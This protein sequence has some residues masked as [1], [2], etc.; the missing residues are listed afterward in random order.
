LSRT[1]SEGQPLTFPTR[2][3][4]AGVTGTAGTPVTGAVSGVDRTNN[5]WYLLGAAT[6]Y[7]TVQDQLKAKLAYDFSPTMR[8]TYTFGLW[9]NDSEGRPTPTC[10]TPP[11]SRSTAARSTSMAA[12]TR[13]GDRLQSL[14]RRPAA[15]HARPDREDQHAAYSM[16]VAAS[17]YDYDKDQLRGHRRAAGALSGGRAAW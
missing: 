12:A 13:W 7:H 8:A 16:E 14:Q 9:R 4:A 15:R 6:Q 11:D 3:L 17:L 10:A 1:D 2:T 5:P